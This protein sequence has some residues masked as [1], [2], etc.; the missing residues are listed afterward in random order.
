MAGHLGA[1]VVAGYFFGENHPDLE[2]EVVA[3]IQADLV[4]ITGGGETIW[5]NPQKA[6]V[7][8]RELF[9]PFPEK[10]S[11]QASVDKIAEALK[12]SLG[13]LRQSGHNVIFSSIAIRALKDHPEYATRDIVGGITE[14]ISSFKNQH[15]GRGYYGREKGWVGGNEAAMVD[16][17]STPPYESLGEMVET[18]IDELINSAPEHR[19]GFGGLFHLI[20]HAAALIELDRYGYGG[21]AKTGLKGHHQHLRLYRALPDLELELGKLK[22]A[23]ES[24]FDPAYWKRQESGQWGAWLTHRIKTLYGFHTLIRF[25]KDPIKR[26]KAND[27]FGYLLA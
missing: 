5:F 26:N 21:L 7:T 11:E 2:D 17:K 4:S 3:A 22:N 6:G 27:A 24:P 14:L 10:T 25:V 23:G 12:G 13:I 19:R 1:A 15:P 20:N 16:Q 9:K 8:A 18:I